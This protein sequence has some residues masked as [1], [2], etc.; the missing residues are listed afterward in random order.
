MKPLAIAT[1]P[2]PLGELTLI[3]GDAALFGLYLPAQQAKART[4]D[5]VTTDIEAHPVLV[6]AAGELDGYFRGERSRFSVPVAL[7]GTPFQREVWAALSTIPF[8]E[9]RS[10][11]WLAE[12][13]G[14]P[15]AVR[16]VG[17]AN[18]RNALSIIVPCHRVVGADGALTGYA[19]GIEAKRWLLEHEQRW[20]PAR[21]PRP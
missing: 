12:H 2:S 15:R 8:G 4:P 6:Q 19:G 7:H 14:R 9:R 21:S 13:V 10:Y 20:S 17:A 18:A 5:A 1:L 16:A 11:R 3:A